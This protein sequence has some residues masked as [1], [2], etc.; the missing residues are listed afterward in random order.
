MDAHGEASGT[1]TM[2]Y[3]GA[4][5]LRWRQVYLRGDA[6][7]LNRDLQT[8]ME[9]LM[10]G[11]ME[12]KVKS[13]ENVEEYEEPLVVKFDVKGQIA[14][15]TGKR[16]LV[17]SDIF[18]VNTKPAFPH[19]KRELPVYFDYASTL[20]D[21]VRVAFPAGLSIESQPS[22]DQI[23]FQKTAVYSLQVQS[24]QTSVTVRRSLLI[25]DILFDLKQ[26]PDLRVFYNKFETKD[27]EPFVLK[28]A[29]PAAGG[30]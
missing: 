22:S 10:P 1:V 9:R 17:P 14:S 3:R 21:A 4:P 29:A 11:G 27:Q 18:E 24:A 12:V 6:A 25:G 19:E 5:A 7:S 26:F 16:L 30:N 8:A 20:L 15:S 2:T 23:P 28:A 13:M